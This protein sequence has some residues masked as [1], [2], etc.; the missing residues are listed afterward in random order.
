MSVDEAQPSPDTDAGPESVDAEDGSA[1]PEEEALEVHELPPVSGEE[2]QALADEK[3]ELF[4]RWVRLQAEFDNY[5][6]RTARER[7]QAR[8]SAVEE[9]TMGFLAVVDNFDRALAAAA[10]A[11][12]PDEHMAG[13]NMIHQQLYTVLASLQVKPMQVYG[14]LFDPNFHEAVTQI[15]HPDVPAGHVA[16]EVERGY[17]I[18]DRVLRP[19]KVAVSTGAAD[20]S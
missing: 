4:D 2:Y 18:G 1:V 17:M 7:L 8:E 15:P 5:R 16:A 13:W 6:K 20:P 3:A 12:I 9:V 14:E 10:D 11:G 19:A